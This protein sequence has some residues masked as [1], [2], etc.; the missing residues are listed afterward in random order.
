M[1]KELTLEEILKN[2]NNN[3]ERGSIVVYFLIHKDEIVYI[4]QTK[5]GNLRIQEHREKIFDSQY[6]LHCKYNELRELETYYLNKF[7]P[8]Y[9]IV[10]PNGGKRRKT[11]TITFKIE[12]EIAFQFKILSIKN[13]TNMTHVMEEYIKKYVT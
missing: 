11:A 3:D 13:G 12:G 8:K 10:F 6:H 2:K 1:N 4:G 9:N 7:K 5:N